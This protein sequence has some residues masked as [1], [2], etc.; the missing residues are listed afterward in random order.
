MSLRT[1]SKRATLGLLGVVLL[2]VVTWA[3]SRLLGP[4]DAQDAALATMRQLPPLRG[5]N[6]FAALWTVEILQRQGR[7]AGRPR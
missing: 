4:T 5:E 1:W 3:T 6:A 7:R 2:V